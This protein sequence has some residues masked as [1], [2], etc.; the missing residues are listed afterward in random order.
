MV[1]YIKCCLQYTFKFV[2]MYLVGLWPSPIHCSFYRLPKHLQ[3][4]RE[5]AT[6]ERWLPPPVLHQ[7][8]ETLQP[9]LLAVVMLVTRYLLKLQIKR[10][11]PWV[12]SGLSVSMA[13]V[14][15]GKTPPTST[16]MLILVRVS[17]Y[18]VQYTRG[19]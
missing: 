5:N 19:L 16:S 4:Q 14:A 1:Q 12:E 13:A 18:R 3:L 8:Q 17:R 2:Y 10:R 6:A 15:T 11:V 7:H 9:P